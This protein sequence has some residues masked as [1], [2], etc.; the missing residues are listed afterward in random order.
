MKQS[1]LVA[2]VLGAFVVL[3]AQYV[4]Q[5]RKPNAPT[6]QQWTVPQQ[7]DRNDFASPLLPWLVVVF[8]SQ[9]CDAC[10]RI[11]GIAKI[12]ESSIV[13]VDIV[14]YQT[15]AETHS[16]YGIDAVPTIVIADGNGVVVKSFIGPQ[17]ATDLWGAI[18][19]AREPGS[20]PPPEAHRPRQS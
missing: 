9:T 6:Q 17:N 4:N 12:A 10:E 3:I 2:L 7:L 19:E 16:R 20:T 5:R 11:S 18:A 8:T 15:K 1:F 14:D 13:A